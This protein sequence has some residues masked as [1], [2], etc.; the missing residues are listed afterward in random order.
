[1]ITNI[2]NQELKRAENLKNNWQ[3]KEALSILNNFDNNK[4]L[5]THERYQFYFLKSS[6]LL[7]LFDSKEAMNYADLAYKESKELETDYEIINALML[8]DRIFGSIVYNSLE[9]I[10]EAEEI[11]ARNNQ[12]SSQ[13][14]KMMKGHVFL[15][16]G[17]H[18]F[19]IGE[20]NRCLRF[21]GESSQ[22]AKEINDLVNVNAILFNLGARI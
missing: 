10:N 3:L 8:K 7:D 9:L 21:L 5:T 4:D 17:C 11:L 15:R 18:Y 14:F 16:K 2:T 12:K 6:I 19:S 22:L 1:M 13:E 20:L